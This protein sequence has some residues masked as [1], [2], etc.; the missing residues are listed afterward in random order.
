MND[1]KEQLDRIDRYSR[2]IEQQ[3]GK[4]VRPYRADGYV[5]L[6]NRYGTQKDTSERYNF[7]AE[8]NYPD[9]QLTM[10]YEG[11]GLFAKIIDTPA[12]EAVKH[13]FKIEGLKDEKLEKFY[14]EALDELDWTETAMI[15]LRWTR[16]FGGAIAVML[17]NDGCDDLSMPL[18]WKNIRSIDDIRVY[19]RAVVTPDYTSMFNYDPS[20]PFS[21]RGSRLGMP[22]FFDVHS[23]Y[24][25][26]RVHESRCL[27]FQNGTLPENT[28]NSV[29]QMWGMPEYVRLHRAVRDAELSHGN[30]SKMLDRSIQAVYKMQGLSN[31]LATEQ[32]EGQVLRRLQTIDMAR[33]LLNS[34]TI[35]SEGEDYDFRTF[36]LSG[37]SEVIDA[38]CNWLSALTNIPQTIMFGRSPAGMNSTGDADFENYYNFCGRIQQRNLRGNLRY[39][40]SVIFQAGMATGEIDEIPKIKIEFNPLKPMSDAEKAE[41]DSKKASTQKIKADTAQ[42][43]V[44]MQALDPTEVRAS[45]ANSDEFDI[46]EILDEYSDEEL[47]PPQPE[48]PAVPG[49]DPNAATGAG[50]IT[51]TVN[52]ANSDPAAQFA[53]AVSVD[54]HNGGAADTGSAPAAAPAAT[55]LPE[56]MSAGELAQASGAR[57]QNKDNLIINQDGKPGSVGVLVVTDGKILCGTRHNDFGYGLIC[58]PGGH[59]DPGEDAKQAAIRETKEEFGITPTELIPLGQGPTEPD[60]GLVP[61]LFIC[62][63]YEGEISCPD[64]EMTNPQFRSIEE[65]RDLSASMFQPFADSLKI[66]MDCLGDSNADGGP[67]SGNWGHEGRPGQIGG[68]K[69]GRNAKSYGATHVERSAKR[70]ER[71]QK[72]KSDLKDHSDELEMYDDIRKDKKSTVLMFAREMRPYERALTGVTEKN[73]GKKID[74]KKK[75]IDK[76]NQKWEAEYFG[77]DRPDVIAQIEYD[78]KR[79]DEDLT[80]LENFADSKAKWDKVKEQAAPYFDAYE[81]AERDYQECRKVATDMIDDYDREIR[82]MNAA[83]LREY[84]D[85]QSIKTAEEAGEYLR[86]KGYFDCKREHD[87]GTRLAEEPED[88]AISLGKCDPDM[89][90]SICEE[91]DRLFEDYPELS[92]KIVSAV[93]VSEHVSALGEYGG[94]QIGLSESLFSDPERIQDQ[95]HNGGYNPTVDSGKGALAIVVHET[96]HAID[97]YLGK[98]VGDTEAAHAILKLT[99]KN[100]GMKTT[101]CK[102]AV[103]RYACTNDFE[104]FA[105]AFAEFRCSSNPRPV[106]K[107][108]GRITEYLIKNGSLP[109]KKG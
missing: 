78:Q 70:Q 66:L 32:G 100:L 34:I 1:I 48:M 77:K 75:E 3:C 54:P 13:G 21:S 22:E 83:I 62:T 65:L 28:T 49:A 101:D 81:R 104:F 108:V 69:P 39:L 46:E 47:F 92:G 8:P 82:Q 35:D 53:Q 91:Y 106:A 51:E 103:S 11:N 27:V 95:E 56:D 10:F 107:E 29:Y 58:G 52:P 86:A 9:E 98:Y 90:R 105:E 72:L 16:L 89:A 5:N 60:T 88:G 7:Q 2:L 45:L 50:Q 43:Y 109:G 15:A 19:E 87:Y 76:L 57:E 73:L 64:L 18:Q 84:P 6:L 12:E 33:G 71:L 41:L 30:A 67:G 93:V 44:N 96:G 4:A 59:I 55:K 79:A 99:A 63:S 40:L 14:A 85:Y 38:T 74:A 25:N 94:R 37:V 36:Q 42:V 26:F 80:L 68:S 61:E 97:E 17:I 24:G 23:K 20:S 31:L 102:K